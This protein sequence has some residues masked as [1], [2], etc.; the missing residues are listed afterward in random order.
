MKSLD[1][2]ALGVEEMETKMLISVN[3]GQV[4]PSPSPWWSVASTIIKAACILAIEVVDSM[5]N[6]AA[7]D[8]Y[9]IYADISH[10]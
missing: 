4:Q 3:G 10:R 1:L 7:D 6:R 5:S 8:G 2:N 9:V